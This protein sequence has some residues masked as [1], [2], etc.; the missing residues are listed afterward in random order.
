MVNSF[1]TAP[2]LLGLRFTPRS[3]WLRGLAFNQN[4]AFRRL[5]GVPGTGQAP[6]RPP[7]WP[8]VLVWSSLPR[9][10]RPVAARPGATHVLL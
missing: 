6:A 9:L 5:P 10:L 1:T 4:A 8:D 2:R 3:A 7:W